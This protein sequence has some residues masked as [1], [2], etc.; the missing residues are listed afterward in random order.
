MIA[1]MVPV[2]IE[3]IPLPVSDEIPLPVSS[4]SPKPETTPEVMLQ[5]AIEVHRS[6][7]V[8]LLG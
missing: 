6:S 1:T 4:T 5:P 7:L 8:V 3:Q 2:V